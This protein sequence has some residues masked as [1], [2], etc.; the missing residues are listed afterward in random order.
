M[1]NALT[2][3]RAGYDTTE[4]AQFL[5]T[6]EAK[7]YNEI[8]RLREQERKAKIKAFTFHP[9]AEQRGKI[10]YAGREI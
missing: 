6:T 3:L 9:K 5:G 8:G 4:I 2:L 10:P 7:A 1:T